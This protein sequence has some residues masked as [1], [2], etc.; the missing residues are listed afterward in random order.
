MAK[1]QNASI[2]LVGDFMLRSRLE[3]LQ[4]SCAEGFRSTLAV[5]GESEAVVANLEMPLSR[6]G[7]QMLKHSTLRSDPEIIHDVR[8]IGVDAVSLANNHM[9]DYGPDALA[10]TLDVCDEAGILRCGAGMNLAESLAPAWLELNG[11]NVALISVSSTLP[12]G[13]EATEG[14]PGIAP[15]RI[16]FSLEIDTNLI[17]EQP[18]TV[19]L[20]HTW[21][22]AEDQDMVCEHI[23]SVKEEADLVIVAIH[24]GVPSYW[25]SP[26]QGLLAE[27]QRP[28]GHALI[29]AGADVIFG[30]HSHSSH[31]IEIYDGR[32]IFYSAGNFIFERPRGFM[33][34]ESFIAQI[35]IDDGLGV[36]LVPLLVDEVG[37]PEL[38]T[39]SDAEKVITLLR[40]LS[41]PFE[42]EMTLEGDRATLKLT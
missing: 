12:L 15:I 8:E 27:Y 2:A 9:M 36:S 19:P 10:D 4:I 30:H 42:T 26:Y 6:R 32:P 18:G 14:T 31:G 11:K 33:E 38:A 35:S 7:S 5:F 13:S 17:N 1:Q 24:W 39:G 3:T 21:T 20:V 34:P 37:L 40:K 16:Y 28:L 41:E 25:L 29:D 23:R 22:R